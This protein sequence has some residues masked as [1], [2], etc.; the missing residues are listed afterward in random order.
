MQSYLGMDVDPVAHEKARTR[1][2]L[3]LHGR[4]CDS[5]SELKAYTLLKNFK[6]IK[7]ALG[8]ADEKLL[9]SGI[10]GIL[11]DLGMSSMQVCYMNSFL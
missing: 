1:I 8:E 6:D 9:V 10:D 7:S 11:M 2:D 4:S 3:V 5:T